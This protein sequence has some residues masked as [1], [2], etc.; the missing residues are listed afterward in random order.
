[1]REAAGDTL[2]VVLLSGAVSDRDE[3]AKKF[4][5]IVA[6]SPSDVPLAEALANAPRYIEAAAERAAREFAIR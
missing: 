1:V 6:A 2:P 4:S 5:E 3:L